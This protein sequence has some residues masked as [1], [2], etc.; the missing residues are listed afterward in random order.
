[1]RWVFGSACAASLI[2]GM[3]GGAIAQ[4]TGNATPVTVDNFI[5]AESDLSA[6]NIM[7]EG[8]LGKLTHHRE[9]A[10]IDNHAVIRTNRDTLYSSGVF[11]LAAG[12][13]TITLPDAGKRFM[14]LQSIS[15]DHYAE[16][17]YG[18]RPRTFTREKVGTR[19]LI[20][21]IRTLVDPANPEDVKKVH[22]LQ[23]AIK[24]YQKSAGKFEV[25]NWDATS[26]KKVRDALLA[27]GAT[28]PDFKRSAP[29]SRSTRCDT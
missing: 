21:D 12:P 19:Y 22:A 27:L 7:K 10:P 1:M 14:S 13:V 23:D 4:S 3:A 9:P 25:P 8:S 15:E 28:T 24:V 18:T 29:R 5:R 11:D 20:V 26:Q 6:A 2:A 16:T 17:F